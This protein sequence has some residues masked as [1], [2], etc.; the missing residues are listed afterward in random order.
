MANEYTFIIANERY[1]RLQVFRIA[2][3]LI[4]VLLLGWFAVNK[5]NLLTGIC[6]A[7]ALMYVL[8]EIFFS[9]KNIK[10][11]TIEKFFLQGMLFAILGWLSLQIYLVAFILAAWAWMGLKMKAHFWLQVSTTGIHI[12]TFFEKEYAWSDLQNLILRDGL[13]TIDLK[14]N[15]IF[16][17]PIK[18][19][20]PA[21]TEENFN[22]FCETQMRAKRGQ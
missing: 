19:M 11:P 22:T 16:Q 20:L 1:H 13:L 7:L 3:L 8:Y 4:N 18:E 12:N 10:H 15:R 21:D 2:L 6:A 5:L 14:S 9:K 17:T